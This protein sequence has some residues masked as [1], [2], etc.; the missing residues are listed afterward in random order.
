MREAAKEEY[1]R[2]LH[3]ARKIG[4][5]RVVEIARPGFATFYDVQYGSRVC[6]PKRPAI[7][8]ET[9]SVMPFLKKKHA[10]AFRDFA[11]SDREIP[12]PPSKMKRER[13]DV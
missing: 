9:M 5:L 8:F 11:L 1:I 2:L 12:Q 10:D 4:K 13:H 3:I 7:K 6:D